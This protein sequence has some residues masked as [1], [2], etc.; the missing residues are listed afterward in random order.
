M[1]LFITLVPTAPQS[2]W[3]VFVLLCLWKGSQPKVMGGVLLGN[4]NVV[5]KWCERM[6]FC[7]RVPCIIL[8][9][10]VPDSYLSDST[11]ASKISAVT[12]MKKLSKFLT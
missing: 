11:A 9:V 5:C 8:K 10:S 7:G 3:F 4:G 1:Y 12:S 2:Q 6:D